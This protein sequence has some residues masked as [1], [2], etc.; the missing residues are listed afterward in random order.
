MRREGGERGWW[1][2]KRGAGHTVPITLVV[3]LPVVNKVG[4]GAREQNALK[5]ERGGGGYDSSGVGGGQIAQSI[6]N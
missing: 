6:M 2:E 4:T 5:R 3:H 1:G